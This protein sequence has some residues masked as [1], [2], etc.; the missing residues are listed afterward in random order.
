VCPAGITY[1]LPEVLREFW[2][3]QSIA[4]HAVHPQLV[5]RAAAYNP[6]NVLLLHK[7]FNDGYLSVENDVHLQHFAAYILSK[8]HSPQPHPMPGILLALAG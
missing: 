2:M 8:Q 5:S 4:C 3:V 1:D 7:P 6:A